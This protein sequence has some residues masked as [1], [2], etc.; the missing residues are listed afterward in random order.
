[1]KKFLGILLVVLVSALSLIGVVFDAT[2]AS[3]N[4][5]PETTVSGI[6][7]EN[8][9]WTLDNSPY[10]IKDTVQIPENVVLTIESG[11]TVI[12]SGDG[13]MFLVSGVIR[14]QGTAPRKIIFEGNGTS[15]FFNVVQSDNSSLYLEHCIL[16]DGVKLWSID[17]GVTQVILRHSKLVNITN[18][19]TFYHWRKV[20]YI[21]YNI[22][23][24]TAG[25]TMYNWFG[26]DSGATVYIMHNLVKG[27]RD[28][29]VQCF[30]NVYNQ[31]I[32]VKYNS[33]IDVDGIVLALHSGLGD[34][35]AINA[36]ENYWG[37]TDTTIIDS[38]IY[39]RNDNISLPN[40]IEYLP[41]L[42]E[43]HPDTPTLWTHNEIGGIINSD[44][45]LTLENSPYNFTDDLLIDE[46]VTLT[47]EPG[48]TVNFNDYFMAVGGTLFAIG[49]ETDKIVMSGS[50][51]AYTGELEGRIVFLSTST[52]SIIEYTE[53]TSTPGV[54]IGIYESSPTISN[55][56][57]SNSTR[58][59]GPG[60]AINMV[61][62]SPT[63]TNNV[64]TNTMGIYIGGLTELSSPTITGNIISQNCVG[65]YISCAESRPFISDNIISN[66][67]VGITIEA[68][69][70][71]G[72]IITRNLIINNLGERF[73][74]HPLWPLVAEGSGI[75]IY[76]GLNYAV[77][78]SNNT[79]CNNI[80]GILIRG[81]PSSTIAQNNIF[82]NTNQSIRNTL[83]YDIDTSSNWWG[84][85]NTSLI[86]QSIIDFYDD[87]ALGKV[88]YSP[89]LDSFNPDAPMLPLMADFTHSPLTLYA[90]G[91]ITFDASASFGECSSIANYTW[92][93][94][95]GTILTLDEPIATHTFITSGEYN[96]TLTVTD[97]FGFQNNTSTTITVLEDNTP[98]VTTD[99]YD[100]TW[101]TSDFT[102]SL[103]A[104]DDGSGVAE[105]YYRINQGGVKAV[106]TDGQPVITSEGADNT[107][108]YWSVDNAG[109][110][111]PINILTGI[112]LDKTPPTIDAP[113]RIP[114]SDILPDQ[115]VK[116]SVN[117][118]D[119]CSSVKNVTLSYK[120][121]D[122]ALWIDLAMTLNSTT[123][124]YEAIIPEQQENTLVKYTITAYD[125][126]ENY[127]AEDNNGQ[128]YVYNVIPEFPL[129][130]ILPL[131]LTATLFIM[132]CKRKLSRT[133][134]KATDVN[135]DWTR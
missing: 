95:D 26:E 34:Y 97:E 57:I 122:S 51:F 50:G 116:V 130:I 12:F 120:L 82:G 5:N 24:D 44:T 53:I 79:I 86:D 56:I 88:N 107:L 105:T 2:E 109:N 91:M 7:W 68:I 70:T 16:R 17:Y 9:T 47:I 98:P 62:A 55:S 20:C 87:W 80:D 63:I 124:L 28:F 78:I 74:D 52:D 48:V 76:S 42:T 72:T 31:E 90:G 103:T 73:S 43:P 114:E 40:Q 84:T 104:V 33:F 100:G 133:A 32:V 119:S 14:A 60:Y 22:F 115:G 132:L 1:M 127:N 131:L 126:A 106:S 18:Y 85:T 19:S 71:N 61:D 58:D 38:L 27:N 117:V 112:K 77:E 35:V 129:W 123:G 45:T 39:D 101:H 29:F 11:V 23:I 94:G 134:K 75:Q 41:I 37:T 102:I 128:Y 66:N 83:D 121:N 54:I 46:G 110:E 21:E 96:V 118:V 125:N 49:T 67:G 65:I 15:N 13:D 113:S 8:T 6:I 69:R 25:F 93:F 99:D 4:A 89:I 92:N 135:G 64:I 111:E 108:E 30:P 36:T 59:A 3:V 81:S 10:I